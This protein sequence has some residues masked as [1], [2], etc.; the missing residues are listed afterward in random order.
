VGTG[1]SNR[2]IREFLDRAKPLV[3]SR[4]PF[5][6]VPESSGSSWSYGLTAAERK[7]AVWLKPLLV[8]QVRFTEWTMDGHLRHPAFLRVPGIPRGQA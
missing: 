7:T 6:F 4:S 2:Q 8:C 5:E 3:Q 1:F